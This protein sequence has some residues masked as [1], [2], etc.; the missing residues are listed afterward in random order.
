M[1]SQVPFILN[2]LKL[3]AEDDD[4]SDE[5]SASSAGLVGDLIVSYGNEVKSLIPES[6]VEMLEKGKISGVDRTQSL[7]GWALSKIRPTK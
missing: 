7:C 4:K 1:V 6:V 2:F 5:N 3:I